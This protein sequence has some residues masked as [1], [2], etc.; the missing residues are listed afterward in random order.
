M[1]EGRHMPAVEFS[2]QG[3]GALELVWKMSARIF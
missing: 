1:T 2:L 3:S